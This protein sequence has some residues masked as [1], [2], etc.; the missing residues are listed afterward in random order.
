MYSPDSD[1][2]YSPIAC[3]SLPRLIRSFPDEGLK[4]DR[5]G[6]LTFQKD[7]VDA[8]KAGKEASTHI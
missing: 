2:E 4:M 8:E 5:A 6:I 3:H 1:A 7:Y